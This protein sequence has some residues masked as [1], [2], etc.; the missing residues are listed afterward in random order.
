LP[1]ASA[2]WAEEVEFEVQDEPSFDSR[3]LSPL[4][5]AVLRRG[6]ELEVCSLNGEFCLNTEI[7][8][9]MH[10]IGCILLNAIKLLYKPKKTSMLIEIN[11]GKLIAY[12]HDKMGPIRSSR[13]VHAGGLEGQ[14]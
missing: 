2:T 7:W 4:T 5:S 9:V 8:I 6:P 10:K 1:S 3:H 14:V 12:F 11:S 13:L